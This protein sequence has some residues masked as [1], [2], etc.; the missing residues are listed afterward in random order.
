VA[1][2]GLLDVQIVSLVELGCASIFGDVIRLEGSLVPLCTPK[3]PFRHT[4][5]SRRCFLLCLSSN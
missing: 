1:D 4:R 2:F 5:L 3:A